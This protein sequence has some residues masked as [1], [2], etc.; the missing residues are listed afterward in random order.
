MGLL[1][2]LG[3]L[4]ALA[5]IWLGV[6][7]LVRANPALLARAVRWGAAAVLTAFALLSL[8]V[9]QIGFAVS[10]AA[11]A[12][13]VAMDRTGF[14]LN[15]L[16]KFF[17]GGRTESSPRA[18][19]GRV[20]RFRSP[21]LTISLDHESGAFAGDVLKGEFAGHTFGELSMVEMALFYRQ[22]RSVDGHAMALLEA[23]LDHEEGPTW[24]I[25]PGGE[26]GEAATSGA[27]PMT[28]ADALDVLGLAPGATRS[29]IRAAHRRLMMLVHPD[30]GGSDYLAARINAAKALLTGNN[31]T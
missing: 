11:V 9:G 29:D 23:Y 3:I 19:G 26:L 6:S 21:W 1:Y 15:F 25:M 24:R 17:P 7:G 22:V 30:R 31:S 12:A 5:L 18:G 4:A 27:A 16:S 10:F 14:L 2:L 28:R 8:R 20:S 13:T